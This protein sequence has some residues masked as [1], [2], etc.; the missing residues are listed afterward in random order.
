[1]LG[2]IKTIIK[3]GCGTFCFSTGIINYAQLCRSLSNKNH[4]ELEN[5]MH[6]AKTISSSL[7]YRFNDPLF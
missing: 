4:L 2:S 6:L 1:M 7:I 3:T 5:V